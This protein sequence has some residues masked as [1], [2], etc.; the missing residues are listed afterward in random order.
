MQRRRGAVLL[1]LVRAALGNPDAIAGA[2]EA[3]VD[4]DSECL[5][6]GADHAGCAMELR[7]LRGELRQPASSA[8][9]QQD[10]K[11]PGRASARRGAP[12]AVAVSFSAAEFATTVQLS[13]LTSVV[14]FGNYSKYVNNVELP[15][16]LICVAVQ[17]NLADSGAPGWLA[18]SERLVVPVV[19]LLTVSLTSI[20]S[21]AAVLCQW[22]SGASCC[23][24]NFIR[25][26]LIKGPD[27]LIS[28]GHVS[29][30]SVT[31]MSTAAR[32]T[33]GA[34]FVCF[35][36]SVSAT[37]RGDGQCV[38]L[39]LQGGV[40]SKGNTIVVNPGLRA[41][42]LWNGGQVFSRTTA[43]VCEDGSVDPS[44]GGACFALVR[45]GTSLAK[46]PDVRIRS[47]DAGNVRLTRFSDSG[48]VACMGP[49]C[50]GLSIDGADLS[51]GDGFKL[52]DD[53]PPHLPLHPRVTR[54]SDTAGTICLSGSGEVG[55]KCL[56]MPIA[57]SGHTIA[58]GPDLLL[59]ASET[60]EIRVKRYTQDIGVACYYPF[61][62]MS[63]DAWERQ[64][65]NVLGL[66]DDTLSKGKDI[67]IFDV[68][69]TYG[70]AWP[71][72]V[73]CRGYQT[74]VTCAVEPKTRF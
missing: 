31:K 64:L 10:S 30:L 12:P 62:P 2:L 19:S 6:G 11:L 18:T 28:E 57:L 51:L 26:S 44:Y 35:E 37:P 22:G 36:G 27:L 61:F 68:A 45:D 53:I 14:C 9:T 29:L 58:R 56:C 1:L 55:Y 74:N 73:S 43:V 8:F 20:S 49:F 72:R 41:G 33:S 4:V 60:W 5:D 65:C 23:S 47:R 7:Q 52:S 17:V 67:T 34:G 16:T 21:T 39:V 32:T 25:D 66:S 15:T 13:Q 24:L 38:A 54:F 42:R 50:R 63:P 3:A 48:G 46:G 70:N 69:S 59:H 40:L 71:M